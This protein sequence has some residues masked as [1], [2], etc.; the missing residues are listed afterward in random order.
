MAESVSNA[1]G[2]RGYQAASMSNMDLS[3]SETIVYVMSD[4]N[5]AV[6]LF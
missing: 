5:K 6:N 2:I 3:K 1:N 4:S